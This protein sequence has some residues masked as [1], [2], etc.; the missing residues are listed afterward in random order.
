[1]I[2]RPAVLFI[3]A[4]FAL[5]F[6]GAKIVAFPS[7]SLALRGVLYQPI[8]KGP[9][10]AVLFSHGSA[11][12][13]YSN[14]AIE[15]LGPVFAKRG[16][17]FFAPYRRGQGL[18]A[19]A[20]PYIGNQ[21]ASAVNKGGIPAGAVT[22]IR[23]LETDHLQDQLAA[24]AWLRRQEFVEKDRIATL[25]NSFGGIEALLGAEH[26]SYCAAIDASGAAESWAESPEI[27]HFLL[28]TVQN[29]R[30]PIFFFQAENDFDVSPSQV[31][32][33]AM[34]KAGKPSEM[35]IYPRYGNSQKEGHSFAYLGS[36]VWMDDVFRFLGQHCLKN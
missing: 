24:L 5:A 29:A 18:S 12:G 10:P 1:M 16:W 30:A 9:F 34:R 35:K 11:P 8:G 36:S 6:P 15:A 31:L 19:S 20:G 7:G 4:L 3:V 2:S 22:M 27:Q 14:K 26:G 21:I 17:V 28:R 25:G 33:A 23:L 13:M 32:F